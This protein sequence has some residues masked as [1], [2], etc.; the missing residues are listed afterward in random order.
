MS[1]FSIAATATKKILDFTSYITYTAVGA[2]TAMNM[3]PLSQRVWDGCSISID[4]S[5]DRWNNDF[6]NFCRNIKHNMQ[7]CWNWD[8]LSTDDKEWLEI[9]LNSGIPGWLE[10]KTTGTHLYLGYLLAQFNMDDNTQLNDN[11]L[12]YVGV[13][14]MLDAAIWYFQDD[15]TEEISSHCMCDKHFDR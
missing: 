14:G 8:F 11:M 4:N 1:L 10:L 9:G 3:L 7:N 15:S 13:I 6:G 2:K 5:L 12:K